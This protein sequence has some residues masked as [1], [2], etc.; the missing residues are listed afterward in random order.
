MKQFLKTPTE[1]ILNLFNLT[2]LKKKPS[3]L[4]MNML[5]FTNESNLQQIYRQGR[6][7]EVLLRH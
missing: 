4:L 7:D 6:I 1:F 2:M 5:D 3:L